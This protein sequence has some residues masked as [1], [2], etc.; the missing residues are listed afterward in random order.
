MERT[1][2]MSWLIKILLLSSITVMALLVTV[3][4]IAITFGRSA[5]TENA[6]LATIV[7][8][9]VLIFIVPVIMLAL[10]NRSI[11]KW[12]IAKTMWMSKGPSFKSI[13]LVVLVYV[14]ALPA[15]NYIVEWNQG[16]HLPQALSG[17]ETTM[18]DMEDT[19]KN[20]TTELLTTQ[21]WGK[22]ILLV[23]LV[24][25]LTGLGEETFFRS[26]LLG[27]MRHGGVNRHVAIW[28]AAII[29]SAIHMQFYG[30]IPRML[31][32]AWFGYLMLWCGE[33]WTPIIAH[34]LN[35]SMVVLFTFLEKNHY[36][37]SNYID[38]LGVPHNGEFPWLAL[39][40]A[41]VTAVVIVLF[42]AKKK[43]KT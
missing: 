22:M 11:E 7:L 17:L 5:T 37:T 20:V 18:R 6:Q 32:G 39:A 31:L 40:S 38:T 23:L 9:N 42:M 26:G 19:A 24:G 10:V 12:P 27:T 36:I 25:A 4:V 8:Q 21:S 29:F 28:T 34:A 30:F 43:N 1:N 41:A 13:L 14:L 15:M 16:L 35:N 33:V 2:K 3:M